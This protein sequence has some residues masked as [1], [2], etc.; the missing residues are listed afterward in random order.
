MGRYAPLGRKAEAWYRGDLVGKTVVVEATDW[1]VKNG[2]VWS[3]NLSG[4]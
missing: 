2:R 4:R 3:T 1:S